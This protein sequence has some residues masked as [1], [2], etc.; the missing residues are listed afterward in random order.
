MNAS[1]T[2]RGMLWMAATGIL[3]TLLNSIMKML[4]HELDP[5]LVGFLRYVLGALVMLAP[6]LRFGLRELW[7]KAPKL[8]LLRG[9]FH[10][11]GMLLWFAALPTVAISEITAIG[12]SGPIFICL[13]A[14]LFLHERMTGARWAA[15]LVGF[16]GVLLVLNP[17]GAGGFSSIS[18]GML[19]MLA[20]GPVF[21]A[22]FLVAK[23][24]TRHERSD[25][26]VLWQHMVVSL[27]LL[28]FALFLWAMP[29]PGQWALLLL[30]GLLGAGGHYCMTRSFRVA[31]ISAVQSV[32]F[33][34]LLWAAILGFF[35][36]GTLPGFWTIVGGAV[37]LASTLWLARRESRVA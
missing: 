3:F 26:M 4:S 17:F 6:A 33:L 5:W 35:M 21:A 19:M 32:K 13:G 10:A 14:V 27:I 22:S 9:A 36:F 28:P 11:T 29:S 31:D 15:V 37:I 16:G 2:I 1:P 18:I 34:E 30:C 25:V 8:Q 23:V 20:S 12:F 7:P 24:L